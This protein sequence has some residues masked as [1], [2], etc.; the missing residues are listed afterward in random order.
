MHTA[1]ACVASA[2]SS[3]VLSFFDSTVTRAMLARKWQ[4]SASFSQFQPQSSVG[5]CRHPSSYS[6]A[7]PEKYQATSTTQ[8]CLFE[9]EGQSRIYE[10]VADH[11]RAKGEAT[12]SSELHYSKGG[13]GGS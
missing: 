12:S 9:Q 4:L 2:S 13:S 6:V 7:P 8:F 1:R 5:I 10:R 3:L 11:E